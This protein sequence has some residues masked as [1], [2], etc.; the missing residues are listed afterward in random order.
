[1]VIAMATVHP[2]VPETL[3]NPIKM[4]LRQ[5]LKILH[6]WS[7]EKKNRYSPWSNA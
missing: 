7:R 4:H 1:V 6:S 2:V 3:I 5:L